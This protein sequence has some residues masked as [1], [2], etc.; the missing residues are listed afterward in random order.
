MTQPKL[1][2]K[3]SKIHHRGVFASE[4]IPKGT[5]IIEYTGEKI[6]EK[7]AERRP[8]PEEGVTYLFILNAHYYIDGTKGNKS[9]Y[10]NHSCDPNCKYIIKKGKILFYAK[11]F[12]KKGEELTIDYAFDKKE[13]RELCNCGSPKCRGFMNEA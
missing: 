9:K 3:K 4:D 11:R 8:D 10:V 6:T 5:F 2:V 1:I 12:I 13:E 7:E